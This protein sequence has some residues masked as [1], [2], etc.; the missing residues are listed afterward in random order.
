MSQIVEEQVSDE[1]LFDQIVDEDTEIEQEPDQLS[2]EEPEQQQEEEQQKPEYNPDDPYWIAKLPEDEQE[3]ARNEWNRVRNENKHLEL[4]Y[5]SQ[6][7][8]VK[9]MQ[10]QN[11][12]LRKDLATIRTMPRATNLESNNQRQEIERWIK[13]HGEDFPTEA[14]ELERLI[15]PLA[16]QATKAEKV[17]ETYRKQQQQQTYAQENVNQQEQTNYLLGMHP[18]AGELGHDPR[19]KFWL[20]KQSQATQQAVKS[21]VASEVSDVLSTFK[22]QN[23][24]WHTPMYPDDFVTPQQAVAS[25]IFGNWARSWKVEPSELLKRS[26]Y[27]QANIMKAFRADLAEYHNTQAAPQVEQNPRV[28]RIAAQRQKQL[29]DR[30]PNHKPSGV[31]SGNVPTDDESLFEYFKNID[32]D[33]TG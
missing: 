16:D 28:S 18:D 6:A 3:F 9:P 21:S 29:R 14:A 27:E 30:N 20:G 23:Q 15:K 1:E 13:R 32:P 11:E 25:P 26:E 22:S 10:Q 31:N 17:L 12:R 24:D 5:K 19:F 8:L 2:S 7:G 4:R 33:L